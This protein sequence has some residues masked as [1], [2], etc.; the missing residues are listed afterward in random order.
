MADADDIITVGGSRR[1]AERDEAIEDLFHA[2]YPRLVHRALALLGDRDL[3]EQVSTQAYLSLW[4]RWGRVGDSREAPAYLD[5]RVARLAS[6]IERGAPRSVIP[7]PT[8]AGPDQDATDGPPEV[9]TARAWRQ[10]EALRAS[11]SAARRRNLTAGIALAAV[12]A[13]AVAYPVLTGRPPASHLPRPAVA[14]PVRP[15]PRAV[16]AR[17][18]LS[19]V[20]SVV[21]TSTQAWAI[22]GVSQPGAI[23]QPGTAT[24]YQLA[25]IDLRKNKVLYRVNLGRQPR[26]IAAGAGRVWLTTPLGQAGGQIVR[27][28]P[29]TGG[30]VRTLHLPAGPCT[31]L[32]FGFGHLFAMCEVKDSAATEFWRINPHTER[33]WHLAGPVHGYTTSIVAAPH[34]FWYVADYQVV[35][36]AKAGG[37]P[38]RITIHDHG[39]Q[40]GPPGGQGL[41]YGDG[42]VWVLGGGEN[43]ARID[44]STGHVVRYYTYRNYDPARAGGLDFLTAGGGWLWFLDNGYPFS[45]VLRVSEATGR[46]AGGVPIPP[47]SCGQE[48]CSQ[49]FYTPGSVWVPTA[50]LLIRIDP[51]R[52]PG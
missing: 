14:A 11:W 26:S 7:R 15:Y 44:P 37:N 33:P 28:D 1:P 45:G 25:A 47:G 6:E 38:Q 23:E 16:A 21:G 51:A 4:R 32:S 22:R 35:V 5:L 36:L 43:L 19:G 30:V 27:M 10:F 13:I 29:A 41:V 24:T 20:I 52:L 17:F 50:E 39:F 8:V 48:V 18:E 46:P 31:A 42:S 2:D 49:I 34:A 12:A 9:D 3:A 40:Y